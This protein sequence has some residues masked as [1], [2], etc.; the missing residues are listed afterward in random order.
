MAGNFT[1]RDSAADANDHG[2]A[3]LWVD[4]FNQWFNYKCESI[5]FAIMS[6]LIFRVFGQ[7]A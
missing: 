7:S 1:V 4:G 2:W 5:A 6:R 3:W